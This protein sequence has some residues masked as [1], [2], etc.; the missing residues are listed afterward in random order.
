VIAPACGNSAGGAQTRRCSD[1]PEKAVV[2]LW[3]LRA[4]RAEQ[5]VRDLGTVLAA[6]ERLHLA[7]IL[8]G[9]DG[10]VAS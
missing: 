8:A 2:S 1:L 10:N 9:G 3:Q 7:D 6:Q 4:L 5:D